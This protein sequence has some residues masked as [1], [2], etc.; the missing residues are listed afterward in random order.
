MTREKKPTRRAI[1]L[2]DTA[3]DLVSNQSGPL[4]L[5]PGFALTPNGLHIDGE[6]SFEQCADIGTLLPVAERCIQ[7]ALGDYINYMEARWG[8]AASQVIDYTSGWSEKTCAIYA[9]LAKRITPDR[10]R[11]DRLTIRH[12]LLV[13]ALAPSLQT[14]W[15]TRAAADGEDRPWTVQ[16][17]QTALK[18]S[19]DVTEETFWVMVAA[20]SEEDQVMLQEAMQAE[21]RSCKALVR[22][23]RQ[24]APAATA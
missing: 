21:G 3:L 6:P 9:W 1:A 22:R 20:T 11:M 18:A 16:R 2:G 17:L 5:A 4:P 23:K 8:E 24:S 13:A 19:D 12:H 15:L 14:R 7:F 10:R